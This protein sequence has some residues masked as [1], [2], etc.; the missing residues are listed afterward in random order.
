MANILGINLS[1]LKPPEVLKRVADFLTD[2]KQH[3]IVTPNPEIILASQKDEEF[4][5]ILNQASL[6]LADGFGLKIA[7]WFFG[8]NIPRITGADTTIEILKMAA[9]QKIKVIILNWENSLSQI[10]DIDAALNK[11]FPGLIFLVLSISRDKF[12][13]PETITAINNFAPEILFTTLGFPHQEKLIF[14][15]I[16][17]LPTVKVALGIGGSFDFITEKIK[18]APKLFRLLGLEWFW[19][20]LNAF[21]YKN[22]VQ[23]INRILRALFIFSGE[24]IKVRVISPWQYRQNVACFLYK[25]EGED[26]KVLIVER[27]DEANHWQLPQGGTDGES[28]AQAGARELR[29]E[30]GTNK[31]I[32][33]ANFKNVHRYEFKKQPTAKAQF[34]KY[35]HKGQN[36]GLFIAEFKGTDNDIKI[37]FWDHRAW[38]WVKIEELVASINPSRREGCK[39]FLDKFQSLNIK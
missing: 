7:G 5:H 35:G 21:N 36:Q 28:I 18:R 16:S 11:K 23:R 12:L 39:K 27:Y 1:E 8:N 4:F 2:G 15:N 10:T 31:F 3:F 17:K 32:A 13:A 29:E 38:K 26:I 37:N 24:I 9:A 22:S 14:H 30:A 19:R 20:L 6:S 25:K 33:R 34:Y